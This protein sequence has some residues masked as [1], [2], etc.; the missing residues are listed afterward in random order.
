[1]WRSGSNTR[2][3]SLQALHDRAESRWCWS[4]ALKKLD[5]VRMTGRLPQHQTVLH[6]AC[7]CGPA[8][9]LP[10]QIKPRPVDGQHCREDRVGRDDMN[11]IVKVQCEGSAKRSS[12]RSA[13]PAVANN[14]DIPLKQNPDRN[15]ILMIT[16][17]S[18]IVTRVSAH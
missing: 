4:D 17:I 11:A 15:N 8:A 7:T 6:G 14:E 16:P 1:M 10:L 3:C 5:T 13:I 18:R 2:A 9:T 12:R